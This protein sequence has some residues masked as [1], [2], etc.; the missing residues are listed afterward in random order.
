LNTRAEMIAIASK[1]PEAMK[2]GT[3]TFN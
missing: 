1:Y 3:G 2:K